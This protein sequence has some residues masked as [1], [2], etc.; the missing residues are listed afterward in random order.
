MKSSF[1]FSLFGREDVEEVTGA[2]EEVEG[3]ERMSFVRGR[4]LVYMRSNSSLTCSCVALANATWWSTRP[5]R[6]SASSSFSGWLVVITRTRPSWD[7]T[8]WAY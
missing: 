7:A 1:S 5:G 6:I 4:S 8:P 2:G 3:E